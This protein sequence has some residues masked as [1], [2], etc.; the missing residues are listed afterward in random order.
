MSSTTID[1]PWPASATQIHQKRSH[2]ILSC[3]LN[4]E[5]HGRRHTTSLW[6]FEHTMAEKVSTI[7]HGIDPVETSRW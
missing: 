7:R 5:T 3:E 1:N 6:N 2:A 4:P